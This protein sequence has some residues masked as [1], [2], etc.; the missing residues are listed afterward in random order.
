MIILGEMELKRFV[1]PVEGFGTP[2]PPRTPY[3]G[4]APRL[5]PFTMLT[6][7]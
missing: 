7:T 4:S 3:V 1:V 2:A 5:V 6:R